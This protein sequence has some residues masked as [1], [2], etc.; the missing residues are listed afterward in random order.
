MA[1]VCTITI[2]AFSGN[3]FKKGEAHA[4]IYPIGYDDVEDKT[5]YLF[6]SLDPVIGE[7]EGFELS[8]RIIEYDDRFKSEY[9]YLSG[10]DTAGFIKGDDR[11]MI[12][13]LLAAA[14]EH[15]RTYAKPSKVL[16]CSMDKDAPERANEKFMLFARLFELGGYSV[17]T[18][19]F[20]HG[21]RCWWMKRIPI[22]SN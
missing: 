18:R 4:A 19:D 14:A 1:F 9:S 12:L 17:T 2:G 15:L 10:K 16:V 22:E 13:L 3:V 21:L 11:K 20:D 8:F 6:I 5:Y 7:V